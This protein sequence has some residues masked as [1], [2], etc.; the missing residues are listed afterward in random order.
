MAK[1][2]TLEQAIGGELKRLR[3][4]KGVRQDT[5]AHSARMF[6]LNWTQST[7]AA[8]EGGRRSLSNGELG[9]LPTIATQ[10][11]IWISRVLDFIPDADEQVIVAPGVEAPLKS[12]RWLYGTQE[13]KEAAPAY[14]PRRGLRADSVQI[15]PSA[16]QLA[17]S[18]SAS[19][20]MRASGT[21]CFATEAERKAARALGVSPDAVLSAAVNQ[22]GH[23]LADERDRRIGTRAETLSRRS[24][25]AVRGRVTRALMSELKPR[26]RKRRR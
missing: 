1:R 17:L 22:W 15:T 24:L 3:E 2:R 23:G 16:G 12:F 18:G 6:G 9:M 4:A 8:I 26:I 5:V 14:D 25:Q 10:A 19:L 21:L 11:G 7:V 20:T 13:E